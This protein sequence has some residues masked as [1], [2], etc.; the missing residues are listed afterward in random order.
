MSCEHARSDDLV[1][2]VV[3]ADV[4]AKHEQTAHVI[5]EARSV[6]ATGLV[7]RPLLAPKQS[8]ERVDRR[9]RHGER[10]LHTAARRERRF[11][12][13]LAAYAAARARI[14]VATKALE[15]KLEDRKSTRLNSSHSQI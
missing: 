10:A 13:R 3:P 1:D 14:G 12:R 11:D 4:F 7:E 5:E 6:E 15:R 2:G 8:R 9:R